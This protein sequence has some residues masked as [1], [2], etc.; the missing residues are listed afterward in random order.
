MVVVEHGTFVPAVFSS[1][2]GQGKAASALYGR[3]ASMLA[4]KRREPF[5]VVMAYIRTKL[6]VALMKSA[7]ASLRGRRHRIDTFDI[8]PS[9]SLTVT[10]CN[11][12]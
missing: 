3:I 9:L 4:D 12:G 1:T 11:I 5:S 10:E 2:G 6:S 7:V 8:E